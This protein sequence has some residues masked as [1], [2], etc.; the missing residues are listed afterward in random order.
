MLSGA[1]HGLSA[2]PQGLGAQL[3]EGQVR[4]TTWGHSLSSLPCPAR[5]AAY[6]ASGMGPPGGSEVASAGGVLRG[7]PHCTLLVLGD[8]EGRRP[9]Q[10]RVRDAD[11]D[12]GTVGGVGARW[13]EGLHSALNGGTW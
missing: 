7:P 10:Q 1:S 4:A 6:R 13:L 3:P 8:W 11:T 9:V 5:P 12:S 2:T